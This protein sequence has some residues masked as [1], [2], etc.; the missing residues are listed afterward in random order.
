ME[1]RMGLSDGGSEITRSSTRR[2]HP[3]VSTNCL[4]SS[5]PSSGGFNLPLARGFF[6]LDPGGAVPEGSRGVP[7]KSARGSGKQQTNEFKTSTEAQRGF[8][9]E[10]GLD[11][12]EQGAAER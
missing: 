5:V 8:K 6:S 4:R 9:D 2:P 10:Q 1:L 3:S 12:V 11:L 7:A